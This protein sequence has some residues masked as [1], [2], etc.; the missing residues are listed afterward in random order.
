[1]ATGEHKAEASAC[2]SNDEKKSDGSVPSDGSD[3]PS[4]QTGKDS[5]GS[6]GRFT[7]I[8]ADVAASASHRKVPSRW[9][10]I[11]NPGV[12]LPLAKKRRW[13]NGL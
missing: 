12:K 5:G 11:S 1:M 3:G 6:N 9:G 8:S 4:I 2:L 10:E 13:K 7:P